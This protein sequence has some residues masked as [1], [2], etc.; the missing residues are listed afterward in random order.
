M[1]DLEA[2]VSVNVGTV[3][4]GVRPNVVAAEA[5]AE[6]DVRVA[7]IE[8]GKRIEEEILGLAAETPGLPARDSG[9]HRPAADGAD[10]EQ[11]T[12]LE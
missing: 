6:V 5:C 8:Q 4:G 7:S 1:T 12:P 10:R 2:G 3:R 9:V 11:R